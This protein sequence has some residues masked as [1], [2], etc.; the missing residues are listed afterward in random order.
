MTEK[1]IQSKVVRLYIDNLKQKVDFEN[2]TLTE[3][4]TKAT[5][6]LPS[7][8][9]DVLEFEDILSKDISLYNTLAPY[10][11]KIMAQPSIERMEYM[12]DAIDF[13]LNFH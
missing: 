3:A 5:L 9:R 10:I 13:T 4:R 12:V 11:K 7:S 2:D 8:R 6:C 1:D